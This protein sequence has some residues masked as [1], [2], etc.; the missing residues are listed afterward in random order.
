MAGL[1][2][3]DIVVSL[4]RLKD[5]SR[6]K[7]KKWLKF[8]LV[9]EAFNKFGNEVKLTTELTEVNLNRHQWSRIKSSL[10]MNL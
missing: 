8:K 5:F 9:N 6:K 4:L 1:F 7:M 3:F 10:I 2:G